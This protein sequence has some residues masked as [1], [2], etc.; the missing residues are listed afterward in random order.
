VIYEGS[1]ADQLVTGE[2]DFLLD[3][4]PITIV[5]AVRDLQVA[6]R[7]N[8]G[9]TYYW[10]ITGGQAVWDGM[11]LSK[12]ERELNR[13]GQAA[14]LREY[15]HEV[16]GV[17][18]Y[19]FDSSACRI[20]DVLPY[21]FSRWLKVRAWDVAATAGGGDFSAGY[22]LA[23][24]PDKLE[25]GIFDIRRGQWGS[26]DVRNNIRDTALDDKR[27]FGRVALSLPQDPGQAGKAQAESFRAEYS[28][29]TYDLSIK[30]V[31][32][33]KGA[34]ARGLQEAWNLGN[35]WMLRNEHT[36]PAMRVFRLFRED[37]EHEFDDDVDAA[38]DG[39]NYLIAKRHRKGIGNRVRTILRHG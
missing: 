3:R 21:D 37:E 1:I 24:H 39:Y 31:S 5:P 19:F 7:Q 15:Q 38:A 2:A 18:G 34:R 33:R 28:G 36:V 35:V 29:L 11:P 23:V 14:F 13:G 20:V 8:M 22:G 26:D 27:L 12:C 25:F 10:A 16:K 32:G 30:P 9:G 6:K 17:D 4:K